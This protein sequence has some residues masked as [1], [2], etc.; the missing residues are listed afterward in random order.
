MPSGN[1]AQSPDTSFLCSP[2]KSFL[3]RGMAP[4]PVWLRQGL[5]K[6]WGGEVQNPDFK[7]LLPLLD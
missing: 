5:G 7:T 2:S 1:M 3:H 4:A 6:P